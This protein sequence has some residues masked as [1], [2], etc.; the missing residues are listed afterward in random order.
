MS[1]TDFHYNCLLFQKIKDNSMSQ[2]STKGINKPKYKRVS[3]KQKELIYK[4][5]KKDGT[6]K[7]SKD[8]K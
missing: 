6:W 5:F 3:Q 7:N 2:V 1:L 4:L 8:I